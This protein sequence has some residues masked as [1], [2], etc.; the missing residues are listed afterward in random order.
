MEAISMA[1]A[2]SFIL[3]VAVGVVLGFVLPSGAR[4]WVGRRE[5][6][7]ATRELELADRLLET[8]V[9]AE[10]SHPPFEVNGHGRRTS[11]SGFGSAPAVGS[12][13]PGPG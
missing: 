6:K 1:I 4:L 13:A 10:E 11:D 5:W 7:E 3:G 8:L 12:P 9:E 2:V